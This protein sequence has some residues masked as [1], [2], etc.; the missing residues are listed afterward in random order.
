MRVRS[1][2]QINHIIKRDKYGG[3]DIFKKVSRLRAGAKE[4]AAPIWSKGISR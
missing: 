1:E 4:D 2:H 3:K